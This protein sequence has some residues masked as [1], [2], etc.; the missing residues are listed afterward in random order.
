MSH[1]WLK[2]HKEKFSDSP[3][4]LQC[5]HWVATFTNSWTASVS[6]RAYKSR[7]GSK[8]DI[9]RVPVLHRMVL[10]GCRFLIQSY[11]SDSLEEILELLNHLKFQRHTSRTSYEL[12]KMQSRNE[13]E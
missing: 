5:K 4:G 9:R 7:L 13:S 12:S 8:S 10:R 3:N 2:A 1:L 11:A 6:G